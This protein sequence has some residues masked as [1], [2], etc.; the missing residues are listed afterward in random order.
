MILAAGRGT[1]MG[2][3][4]E[5]R[6]KPLLEVAGQPIIDHILARLHAAGVERVVVNLHHK[7]DLLRQ[8]LAGDRQPAIRFSDESDLLLETGGGIARALA[9]L[10]EDPFLAVN[11]DVIWRDGLRP[12]LAALAARFDPA[13]MD[14]LL[15]LQPTVK[16]RAYGG[17]GDFAMAPDGRLRRR[18]EQAVA[19]FVF[20]GVQLLSPRLFDGCPDGAFSINLLYDRAIDAGRLFGL[21]HDGDW[22]EM[23]APDG[24][25]AATDL[26]AD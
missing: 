21:R 17:P 2:R 10:G 1:R 19:P 7:G 8:H 15:L 20:T 23:N 26:L 3:L 11:G 9:L 14:A 25:Q 13:E 6:P 5:D 18:G 16:A 12:S 24:L 22:V 4:T